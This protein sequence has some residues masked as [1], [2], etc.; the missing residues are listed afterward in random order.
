MMLET[1]YSRCTIR[2][3]ENICNS[4]WVAQEKGDETQFTTK[5][6]DGFLSFIPPLKANIL[7]WRLSFYL[8]LC[9]WPNQGFWWCVFLTLRLTLLDSRIYKVLEPNVKMLFKMRFNVDLCNLLLVGQ[10]TSSHKNTPTTI[11]CFEN[12]TF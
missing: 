11:V 6:I 10:H 3:S 7:F 12:K 4:S 2:S 9:I 1:S 5:K 8:T